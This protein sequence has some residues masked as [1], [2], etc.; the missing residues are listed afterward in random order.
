MVLVY[1][2]YSAL[3]SKSKGCVTVTRIG[4]HLEQLLPIEPFGSLVIIYFRFIEGQLLGS[5]LVVNI[6]PSMNGEYYKK[7]KLKAE[8]FYNKKK[9][10]F[11]P[12]FNKEVIL[13]SDGFN[14]LVFKPNRR[15]RNPK[16]QVLKFSLLPLA[17]AIIK[18]SG[19]IQ[20]FRK[21]WVPVTKK[22]KHDGLRKTKE[23]HYWG[24][25]AIVG[26]EKIKIRTI[27]RSVGNGPII[28]W[29]VMPFSNL[30]RPGGQKLAPYGFEET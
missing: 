7:Q 2:N 14:H 10:I 12:Y 28:F 18:K 11:C 29:S 26:E 16:E 4:T 25:I 30:A 21:L 3:A 22:S 19:T 27:L 13:N 23:I 17:F 6:K 8:E 9:A 20:E 5:L 1:L 24:L 15:P